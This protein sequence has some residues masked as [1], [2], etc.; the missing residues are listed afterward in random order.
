MLWRGYKKPSGYGQRRYNGSPGVG[1][2][3]AAWQ[4]KNGLIPEGYELHHKCQKKA[5]VNLEHLELIR[6]SK[7]RQMHVLGSRN[8]GAKLTEETAVYAMARLLAG[9]KQS[10]V[11]KA[12]GVT[13]PAI[14]LLWTGARWKHLFEQ[15]D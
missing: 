6:V 1:A 10:D 2:H 8:P 11:A 13:Q 7:H 3:L 12:F 4:E 15:S 5:C 9:E 14:S